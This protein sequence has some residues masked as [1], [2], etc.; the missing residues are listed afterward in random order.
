MLNF[1]VINCGLYKEYF[2]T[3][4]TSKYSVQVISDGE[5]HMCKYSMHL[6]KN[7]FALSP[8]QWLPTLARSSR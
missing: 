5:A 2:L 7:D 8:N 3:I 6:W 4:F 1:T